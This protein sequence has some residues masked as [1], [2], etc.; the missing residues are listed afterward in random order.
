MFKFDST[1]I[2]AS[3]IKQKLAT[4]N[5]PKYKIYTKAN[6]EYFERYGTESK[7]IIGTLEY[8]VKDNQGGDTNSSGLSTHTRY[9]QYIKDGRIKEY[10]IKQQNDGTF[11]PGKWVDIGPYDALKPKVF[12]Y[13][14][15]DLNY[16]KKLLL[17]NNTYDYY[18]HEY[19]GD[20][21]RFKRDYNNVDLMPLYNCFSNHICTQF[22]ADINGN[23]FD[24]SDTNYKIYYFPVKLFKEYTI[25]ISS[26]LPI[27]ICCGI[28]G[29]Y[30]DS[31]IK[32]APLYTAT[33]QR[34]NSSIFSAPFLY[35]K[36]TS[37]DSLVHIDSAVE[38]AQN[39]GDLKMFIKVPVANKSSIVVLEGNYCNYNDTIFTL[40]SRETNH[41]VTNY[42]TEDRVIDSNA[43]GD[44]TWQSCQDFSHFKAVTP[45]QLLKLNTGE[46]YPF[47]DRL[48]E[49]LVDQAI[50][51]E[52]TIIDNVERVKTVMEYNNHDFTNTSFW[53][54]KIRCI[55]Y[56]YI[57]TQADDRSHASSPTNVQLNTFDINHDILGYIDRTVEVNYSAKHKDNNV[58]IAGVDIYKGE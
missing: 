27:E 13:D 16:T 32:F 39:E 21:L 58:T 45:L 36:L 12:N 31:R 34:I 43:A 22:Y 10:V 30:Q 2:F 48:V 57:T 18:T 28:Y 52:D 53:E 20:Y 56:D 14:R 9:I 46:S 38:L 4:F 37:L 35:T 25:A 24:T 54:D 1:H 47:A 3:Y 33:Y 8:H 7:E 44:I 29:K 15:P 19:L 55:A 51:P 11:L 49:Y 6:K 17:K 40:S 26:E 41:A 5:L 50:T 23:I 42:S